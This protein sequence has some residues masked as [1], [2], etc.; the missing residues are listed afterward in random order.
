MWDTCQVDFG[1]GWG[2]G[3]H[4]LLYKHR[5]GFQEDP[6][7]SFPDLDVIAPVPMTFKPQF[8]HLENGDTTTYGAG[9][10]SRKCLAHRRSAGKS[11]YH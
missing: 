6:G 8:P 2:W 1:R 3:A 7:C 5:L 11:S 4:E 9:E 10:T